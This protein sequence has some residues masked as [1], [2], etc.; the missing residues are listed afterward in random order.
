MEILTLKPV[1][2]VDM[3]YF[4][5]EEAQAVKHKFDYLVGGTFCISDSHDHARLTGIRID[6]SSYRIQVNNRIQMGYYCLFLFD[7]HDPLVPGLF[8]HYNQL[9]DIIPPHE[10]I[11]NA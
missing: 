10:T 8:T 11:D 2:A 5:L 6:P 1:T 3:K 4:T 7:R 9:P